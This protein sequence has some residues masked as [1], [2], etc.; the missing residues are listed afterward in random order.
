MQRTAGR[1]RALPLPF[2]APHNRSPHHPHHP[3]CTR[4]DLLHRQRGLGRELA[5]DGAALWRA[6]QHVLLRQ[7]RPLGGGEEVK[8]AWQ[9]GRGRA[10]VGFGAGTGA[11][12][13]WRVLLPCWIKSPWQ[14]RPGSLPSLSLHATN[15]AAGSGG[16]P[17]APALHTPLS[18]GRSRAHS[19]PHLPPPLTPRRR[20]RRRVRA[21]R[22]PAPPAPR[23]WGLL[24]LHG[25][26]DNRRPV[27]Q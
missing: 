2:S 1:H 25:Q 16:T 20:W 5:P 21:A 9:A 10:R 8:V 12:A 6:Q 7:P 11:G 15:T 26:V 3:V 4:A 23:R 27:I 17:A 19:R 14:P 22:V 13:G 24:R 18:A